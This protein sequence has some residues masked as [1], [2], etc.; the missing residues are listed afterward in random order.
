MKYSHLWDLSTIPSDLLNQEV[1]RRRRAA[2]PVATYEK[3]ELCANCR[4]VELNATQRRKPC[5]GCGY[6]HPRS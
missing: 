3:K 1:G 5:P 2:G 4:A 6:K